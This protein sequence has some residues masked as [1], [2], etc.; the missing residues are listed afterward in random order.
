MVPTGDERLFG[1]KKRQKVIQSGT[2]KVSRFGVKGN[3]ATKR[4]ADATAAGACAF[5][6]CYM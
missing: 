3:L 1:V 2:G 4:L 6:V 5:H